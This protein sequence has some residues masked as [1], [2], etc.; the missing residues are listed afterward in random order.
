MVLVLRFLVYCSMCLLLNATSGF[1]SRV[2]K[3]YSVLQYM[4]EGKGNIKRL[5]FL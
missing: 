3:C 2:L 1:V 4:E 5:K